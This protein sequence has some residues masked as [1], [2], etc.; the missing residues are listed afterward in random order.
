MTEALILAII[1]SHARA[2]II[3]ARTV[4]AAPERKTMFSPNFPCREHASSASRLQVCDLSAQLAPLDLYGLGG[5]G[6]A[7]VDGLLALARPRATP[8]RDCAGH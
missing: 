2:H 8:H 6:A 5:V 3:K 1:V 4:G 7:V